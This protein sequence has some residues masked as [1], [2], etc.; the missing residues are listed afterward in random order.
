MI[1]FESVTKRYPDG[2]VALDALDLEVADGEIVVFVGP[3]GCGKTTTMRLVNRM[4]T[5][6]SGRVLLDGTDVAEREPAALR[7]GIGYVIQHTGLFP[8]YTVRRN[9]G[10]VPELE[11]WARGRRDERVDELLDVV[12]L[13]SEIAERY[14]HQLSGGQRQRV[15]VARALA[16]DPAVML[17]DEPFGAVD[18]LVRSRLQEEFLR[19][20]AEVRKT[21]VFVT[22]DIDE[23]LAMGDRIA[24]LAEGGRLQQ[25]ATPRELLSDPAND[26]VK[27]FLGEERGLKRLSLIPVSEVSA[28]YGPVVYPDDDRDVAERSADAAGLDWVIALTEAHVLL[29]WI[30]THELIDGPMRDQQVRPFG[31][32]VQA[33]DSLRAALNAMVTN[34][35]AV[36]V[37][38]S[39]GDVYEGLLSQQLIAKELD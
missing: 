10:T 19:L 39:E 25:Y 26:F 17:M 36:A 8:H 32:H 7:R 15:G 3:S 34:Q 22:H 2:T 16:A 12:G 21:I 13:P 27:E 30:S 5:P 33:G 28:E 29:G 4:V 31:L 24:I 23:A 18:P 35:S 14:P 9:I 20:Q 1:T 37:R 6:T 11:G 38:V